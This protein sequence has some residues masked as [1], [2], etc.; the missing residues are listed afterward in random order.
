MD[1]SNIL[2]IVILIVVIFLVFRVGA[3]LMK[4][5]LG[6]VAIGIVIWLIASLFGGTDATVAS[7]P[8]LGA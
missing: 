7:L 5:L 1:L 6:L 4:G 8:L 3:F 2:S